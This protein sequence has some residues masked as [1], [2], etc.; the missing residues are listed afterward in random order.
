[1]GRKALQTLGVDDERIGRIETAYRARDKERLR[2][3]AEKGTFSEEARTLF[4]VTR[5]LLDEDQ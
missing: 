1:M 4:K 3:Q 5:P 2:V